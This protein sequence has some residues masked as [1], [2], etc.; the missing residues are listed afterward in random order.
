MLALAAAAAAAAAGVNQKHIKHDKNIL[1]M[2]YHVNY[3]I[4][5]LSS[6]QKILWETRKVR[7]TEKKWL[8]PNLPNQHAHAP[9]SY[10]YFIFCPLTW[11]R[12][13]TGLGK[14]EFLSVL[15]LPEWLRAITKF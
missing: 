7:L 14:I 3:T 12:A 2:R 1:K 9:A 5:I 6:H 10:A 15:K 11:V 4:A 8:A 13:H